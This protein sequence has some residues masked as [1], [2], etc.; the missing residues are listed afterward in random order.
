ML[1]WSILLLIDCFGIMI[2]LW[3]SQLL[4]WFWPFWITLLLLFFVGIC[5]LIYL[6]FFFLFVAKIIFCL[7]N[8]WKLL[9][10]LWKQMAFAAEYTVF[11]NAAHESTEVRAALG[12]SPGV[13]EE[14]RQEDC[15]YNQVKHHNAR[16][17][18]NAKASQSQHRWSSPCK[19][20]KRVCQWG[21][22]DRW[23]SVG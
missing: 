2:F 5:Y 22:G 12:H 6:G 11:T 15:Q 14:H 7:G 10:L 8:S 16:H 18:E 13:P 21:D 19:K 3:I 4:F 9:L 23:A 17:A 1:F 20:G